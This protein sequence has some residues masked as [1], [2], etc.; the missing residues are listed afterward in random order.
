MTFTTPWGTFI[1]AKMP[2]GLM[3]AGATFQRVM[4]IAFSEEKEKYVVIYLDYITMFSKTNPYHLQHLRKVF[5]KCRKFGKAI[6][7]LK[8][9]LK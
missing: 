2:F 3:N 6:S 1:Y 9:A 4:D 5:L 7:F 8:E